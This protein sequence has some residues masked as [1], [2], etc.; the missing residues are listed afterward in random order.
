MI[1]L[2]ASDYKEEG[3]TFALLHPGFVDTNLAQNMTSSLK[4]MSPTESATG[5]LQV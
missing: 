1:S 2:F 5:L 3:V 4:P